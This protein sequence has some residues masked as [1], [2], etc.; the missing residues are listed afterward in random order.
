MVYK[1][2]GHP[3]STCTNRVL[4]VAKEVGVDVEFHHIDLF[5]G[6]HK[7]PEFL[8][9]QPFG[10]VPYFEDT[11]EGLTFYE[12]RAISKY[13]ATKAK[14][15]NFVALESDPQYFKKL[16][17]YE[18]AISVET[19]NF[20]R[21]GAQ[22]MYECLFKESSGQGKPDPNEI[23]SLVSTLSS[24]L[25]AYETILSKQSYLA[26]DELT[27]A[28]LFH[29]PIIP[30]F[31]RMGQGQLIESRS[32]VKRWWESIWALKSVQDVMADESRVI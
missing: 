30:Y 5:K 15:G 13:I 29:A 10:Q 28:D 12:S 24:K 18:Q 25:D 3:F 20:E 27:L 32:N 8:K 26:G 14:A 17:L 31:A 21:F 16:A 22:L 1:L 23:D 19:T 7:Q 6:E 2:Y 4:I 9:K 11:E